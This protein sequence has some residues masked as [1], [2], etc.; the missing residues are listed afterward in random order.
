M[1]ASRFQIVCMLI[2]LVPVIAYLLLVLTSR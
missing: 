1:S 2:V